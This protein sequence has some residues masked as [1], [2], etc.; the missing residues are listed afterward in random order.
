[1][2]GAVPES[3]RSVWALDKVNV[4]D[5]GPDGDVSTTADNTLFEVEGVFVP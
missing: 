3:K 1:M 2:P 5:A 4:Y